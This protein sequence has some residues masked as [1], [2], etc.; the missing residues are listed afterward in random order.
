[1]RKKSLPIQINFQCLYGA[2]VRHAAHST[3]VTWAGLLWSQTLCCLWF[4][5]CFLSPEKLC[6]SDASKDVHMCVLCCAE[7]WTMCFLWALGEFSDFAL[8]EQIRIKQLYFQGL[9]RIQQVLFLFLFFFKCFIYFWDREWQSMNRGGAETERD[10]ESEAGSRLWAVDTE[11]D[12]GLK[13]TDC[14]IMAWAEAGCLTNWATQV[15]QKIL[16]L[17]MMAKKLV[18]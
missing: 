12:A 17:N 18:G 2:H 13:L 11:P 6:E 3:S 8:L 10:T 14:E 15:P 1:M 5:L 7:P 4:S 9:K 16:F